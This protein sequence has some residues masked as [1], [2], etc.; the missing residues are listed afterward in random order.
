M[1]KVLGFQV[2]TKLSI[3]S[4]AETKVNCKARASVHEQY[5]ARGKEGGELMNVMPKGMCS[6]FTVVKQTQYVFLK[7]QRQ[8]VK[9]SCSARSVDAK[10]CPQKEAS[11]GKDR[12]GFRLWRRSE[13]AVLQEILGIRGR[14]GK[15]TCE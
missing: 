5:W 4:S 15:P 11:R 14:D 10:Q 1:L 6:Q 12:L 9:L 2:D 7:N 8:K 3:R 13:G